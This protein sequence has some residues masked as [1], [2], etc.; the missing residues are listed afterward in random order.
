M[1]TT[2]TALWGIAIFS[3]II[4]TWPAGLFF[5]LVAITMTISEKAK[6]RRSSK[7]AEKL[8]RQ[9]EIERREIDMVRKSNEILL[10][11]IQDEH[12]EEGDR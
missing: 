2:I 11:L 8:E 5:S 10:H 12:R 3:F 6:T 1:K 7:E 9:R 4:G